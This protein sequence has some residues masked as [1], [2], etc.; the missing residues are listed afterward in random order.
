MNHCIESTS[1]KI[2]HLPAHP[3]Q[4]P[5][6]ISSKAVATST[7][8]LLLPTIQNTSI[9][10]VDCSTTII[11]LLLVDIQIIKNMPKV[12]NYPPPVEIIPFGND[13]VEHPLI[14]RIYPLLPI[15]GSTPPILTTI[16]TLATTR[17]IKKAADR[18]QGD[19][20]SPA[21]PQIVTVHNIPLILWTLAY[22]NV[23][24]LCM[25]E[26]RVYDE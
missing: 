18:R 8:L 21:P 5:I 17:R 19:I 26:V 10:S 7:L 3:L 1:M 2:N 16:I 23:N 22:L 20:H 25:I 11:L 12:S 9:V 14:T 6:S 13:N 4:L 24:C 15:R